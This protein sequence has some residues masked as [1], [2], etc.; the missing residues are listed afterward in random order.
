M[1][2]AV[3][4]AGLKITERQAHAY[5]VG[6]YE[7]NSKPGFDATVYAPSTDFKFINDTPG[8]ILIQT[9]VD[10]ANLYLK[11]ELYGTSDGRQ[12]TIS[13]IRLWD[14][15]P[16]PEAVYQDDPSLAPGQV[17]QVDWASWGAKT[18]F[19]WQVARNGEVLQ[20]KTFYSNYAPWRAVYLRGV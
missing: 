16:P 18:A 20:K 17:Q 2:R 12:V 15:V 6:Y 13:N 11:F 14:Q 9:T 8:H 7:Q 5:R 3:L 19:D 10:T 4:D 1:F